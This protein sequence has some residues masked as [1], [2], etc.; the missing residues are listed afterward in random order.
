MKP[1]I[2]EV[3]IAQAVVK[4]LNEWQ[5]E[6]YQEVIGPGG[7]CDIVARNKNI[8]W[9]VECK[10]SFGFPVLSQAYNWIK[11]GCAHYVSVAV[12]WKTISEFGKQICLNYGIGILYIANS[13]ME[14]AREIVSPRLYR[15]LAYPFELHEQQK[16]FKQAGSPGGGHWTTF[17][18]TVNNLINTVNRNPGIEFNKLIKELDHHYSSLSTAKSCLKGFIGTKVIP[19]LRMATVNKKLCVFPV[20]KKLNRIKNS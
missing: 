5:W 12:P 9:A 20:N 14:E 13:N 1:K 7:R 18:S 10:T 4:T 17:K 19:E 16:N 2:A 6:V 3:D 8:I 11:W 15:K